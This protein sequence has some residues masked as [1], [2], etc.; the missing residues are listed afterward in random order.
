MDK[1]TPTLRERVALLR[2]TYLGKLPETLERVRRLCE[3]LDAGESPETLEE[4]L[5]HAFHSIKGTAA[6]FGLSDISAAAT[7]AEASVQAGRATAAEL[8]AVLDHLEVCRRAALDD[9]EPMPEIGPAEPMAESRPH[10]S[11]RRLYVCDDERS[12]GE[13]L[14]A[15]LSCFGYAV[16]LFDDPKSL[17]LAVL[18]SPPDAVIMD[19]VFPDGVSGTDMVGELQRALAAP[20]PVVFMST[21]REFEWRLKAVQAGGQAYFVKPVRAT[22]LV[23]ILDVLTARHEPEPFRVLVVDDEPA[24]AGY[25]SA[26][27]EQ[28]GMVTRLLHDPAEILEV[29]AA[30]KPDLVLMDMYMPQCSGRDLSRLIRQI[31]E[32]VSLPIVFLSSETDKIKQVSALRV[33]AEGFLTKPIQPD[34]LISAVAIRAERMRT[35][36]SLMVRDSLT[37]L[38]NHTFLSQY[39]DTALANAH[40]LDGQLCFVM[41]D[42]DHF[43]RVNDT[44]G[45]PAGD[46]VL[47]A[48]ARV[49][50]QR[51]RHADTVGRYGGEEF[52]AI[53]QNVSGDEA[54]RIVDGIREDFS[55]VAFRAG[56]QTFFCTFSGGI[57]AY[58]SGSSTEDLVEAADRALYAAKRDGRNRIMM[59]GDD[60]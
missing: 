57:A 2:R 44:Y 36:R 10:S 55:K 18:G 40:R 11:R 37:G 17:H 39:L 47:V 21:R 45:H 35:L 20:P 16:S 25:H 9:V 6:S 54:L 29:L 52:A 32:F 53:L 50:Q 41:L 43:K 23:D 38:F 51:L 42:V 48:L 34:D 27:L 5:F 59:A 58:R 1:R 60:A 46:Q 4:G 7:A 56:D 28:S 15:Q 13:Q 30:F 12:V 49:L 26:I 22:D 8:A 24:V 33:G 14:E 3:R 31:P 19:I